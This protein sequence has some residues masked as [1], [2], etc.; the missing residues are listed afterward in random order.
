MGTPNKFKYYLL[1]ASGDY[2]YIDSNGNVDTTSTKTELQDSPSNWHDFSVTF[3][4]DMVYYGLLR[5]M[6]NRVIFTWD[7]AKILRSIYYADGQAYSNAYAMFV[8]EKRIDYANKWDYYEFYRA[9]VD[10]SK[11]L[12]DS[13]DE[14]GRFFEVGLLRRSAY[15]AI[16]NNEGT[17]YNIPFASNDATV[18]LDGILLD[19]LYRYQTGDLT[20]SGAVPVRPIG[21]SAQQGYII[22]LGFYSYETTEYFRSFI[23]A[24]SQT[25]ETYLLSTTPNDANRF[26]ASSVDFSADATITG[27]IN[28]DCNS[29]EL[30]MV[31]LFLEKDMAANT[32]ASTTL[33]TS[34]NLTGSSNDVSFTVNPT[35]TFKKDNFSYF[36][37]IRFNRILGSSLLDA[38][39][40]VKSF[41]MDLNVREKLPETT[42]KTKRYGKL[43]EEILTNVGDGNYTFFSNYL[44][45]SFTDAQLNTGGNYNNAPYHTRVTTGNTLRGINGDTFKTTL[46]DCMQTGFAIWG[47]GLG[48]EG[49]VIRV[50]KISHF[51]QQNNV[52]YTFEEVNSISYEPA[53]S[54]LYRHI[55]YGYNDYTYE[56][57][58]GKFE[59]NSLQEATADVGAVS[60]ELDLISTYR[61]D[62]YGIEFLRGDFVDK[63]TTDTDSD[64]GIFLLDCTETLSSG[65][66]TLRRYAT[67]IF[68]V[69]DTVNAYNVGLWPHKNLLRGHSA[70][71]G[72]MISQ[73]AARSRF[74]SFR[75]GEKNTA[76]YSNINGVEVEEQA[77]VR[78]QYPLDGYSIPKLFIPLFIKFQVA[79]PEGIIGLIENN[80][81]GEI[82]V[83]DANG[84][85]IYGFIYEFTLSAADEGVFDITLICS[86]RTDTNI[87]T[88]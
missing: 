77:N 52:I 78:P 61:A 85:S 36:I 69:K 57:L 51:F 42:P 1:N 70:F 43:L 20:A 3:T 72:G 59:V 12:R 34:A 62:I 37:E 55:K 29:M 31:V 9:E 8:I 87:L 26:M 63:D 74:V 40:I 23:F 7:A 65:S 86:P 80:P 4:R 24:Q 28:V 35:F 68:E 46:R 84:N 30:Q 14:D 73:N 54:L 83:K 45:Q 88:L 53:T 25:L 64:N 2:Y 81:Y 15:E 48:I 44:S 16:Q 66:Y 71:L 17:K 41:N 6:S 11:D 50:E 60:E 22:P 5:S 33:F 18:L 32:T 67:G 21:S 56:K 82:E 39:V 13:T 27:T 76:A 79:P 19:A 75:S 47:L 10:F 58:N 49:S 38:G